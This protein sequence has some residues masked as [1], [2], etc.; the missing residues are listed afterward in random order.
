[1]SLPSFGP[2]ARKLG[3]ISISSNSSTASAKRTLLTFNSKAISALSRSTAARAAASGVAMTASR[4]G[5][6][7]FRLPCARAARPSEIAVCA[8]PIES[9]AA[10]SG[11]LAVGQ[12]LRWTES[13]APSA[14][15]RTRFC[16]ISSAMNGIAGAIRRQICA[17]QYQSVR[18]AAS[19]SASLSDRQKRAREPRMYQ[20]ERSSTSDSTARA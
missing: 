5:W 18:N 10:E 9:S 8:S 12:L 20:A 3:M 1:M 7:S 15:P 19:L 2:S 14:R 6:R 11:V 17:R 4:R 13:G 16:Q